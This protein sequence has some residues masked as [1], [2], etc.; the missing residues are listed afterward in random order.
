MNQLI[1]IKYKTREGYSE[2]YFIKT[3]K[4]LIPV[5]FSQNEFFEIKEEKIIEIKNVDVSIIT[6]R[7]E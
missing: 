5:S 7:I 3:K 6:G 2:G 4:G 1:K